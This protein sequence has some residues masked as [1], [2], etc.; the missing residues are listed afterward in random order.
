MYEDALKE[1]LK[2][3]QAGEKI[4]AHW[5][6]EPPEDASGPGLHAHPL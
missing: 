2:K 1:L 5:R 4:E 6:P 3:K